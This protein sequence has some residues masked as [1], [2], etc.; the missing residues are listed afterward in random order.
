[1]AADRTHLG[2]CFTFNNMAAVAADP[3]G[4]LLPLK[5]LALF[6]VVGQA[7]K[8]RFVVTFDL[9]YLFEQPFDLVKALFP[10]GGRKL[11][12]HVGP[13][14]VFPRGGIPQVFPGI[15]Y[16]IVEQGKPD[17]GVLDFVV[18]R[19]AKNFRDLLTSLLFGFVCVK[20]VLYSGL[21]LPRKR[22]GEVEIRLSLGKEKLAA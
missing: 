14:I 17:F 16:L 5:D 9:A 19:L 18:G 12:V 10:G 8:T 20:A 11:N 1:M 6:H 4:I 22:T 7:Q 21:A 15:P 2:R 3:Y 13:L